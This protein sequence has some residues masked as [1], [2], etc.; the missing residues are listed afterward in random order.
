MLQEN[1]LN[2]DVFPLLQLVQPSFS[3]KYIKRKMDTILT[4]AD[5]KK[6]V[7]LDIS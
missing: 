1:R 7:F 2:R 5:F 4:G 3:L 6:K